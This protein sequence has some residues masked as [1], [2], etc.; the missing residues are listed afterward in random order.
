[1]LVIVYVWCLCEAQFL[2]TQDNSQYPMGTWLPLNELTCSESLGTEYG[3]VTGNNNNLLI[4]TYQHI[5]FIITYY[6]VSLYI[7]TYYLLL[8]IIIYYYLLLPSIIYFY[9]I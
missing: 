7:I 4:I 5:S 6:D 3:T 8:L 1:M 9:I 2:D